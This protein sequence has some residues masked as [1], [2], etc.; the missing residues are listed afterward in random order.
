MQRYRERILRW[1]PG[2]SIGQVEENSD[3]GTGNE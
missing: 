2:L 1:F 3:G